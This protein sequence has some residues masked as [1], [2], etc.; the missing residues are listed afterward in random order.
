MRKLLVSIFVFLVFTGSVYAQNNSEEDNIR[1]SGIVE[2]SDNSM[3]ELRKKENMPNL[4]VFAMCSITEGTYLQFGEP[5]SEHGEYCW[6]KAQNNDKESSWI[7]Y[8]NFNS[9]YWQDSCTEKCIVSCISGLLSGG[10]GCWDGK[11]KCGRPT[12]GC[13]SWAPVLRKPL[14]LTISDGHLKDIGMSMYEHMSSFDSD[15]ECPSQQKNKGFF[16]LLSMLVIMLTYLLISAIMN[17]SMRAF[18]LLLG[19]ILWVPVIIFIL[20]MMLHATLK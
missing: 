13:G 18:W 5:K 10:S 8:I 9:K 6:C 11:D 15:S 7:Y 3:I 1:P 14:L 2:A 17:K 20:L 19:T 4:N 12:G 16:I